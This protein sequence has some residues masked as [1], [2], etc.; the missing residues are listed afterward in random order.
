M[1]RDRAARANLLHNEAGLAV[2]AICNH[3]NFDSL[4]YLQEP[5]K[6]RVPIYWYQ[7]NWPKLHLDPSELGIW[8]VFCSL[9]SAA[10]K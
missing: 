4:S 9:E 2:L 7:T 6:I 5:D 8:N 3:Q 10:S 1:S